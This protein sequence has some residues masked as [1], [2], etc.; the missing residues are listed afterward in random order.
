MKARYRGPAAPQ[1]TNLKDFGGNMSQ[2]NLKN[3]NT[4]CGK[5]QNVLSQN[6]P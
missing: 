2:K 3:N 4:G 5:Q 6:H 1:Q